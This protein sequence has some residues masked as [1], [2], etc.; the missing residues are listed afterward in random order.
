LGGIRFPGARLSA[1]I[2]RGRRCW[3]MS[4]VLVGCVGRSG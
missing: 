3:R 2:G 1:R 4:R